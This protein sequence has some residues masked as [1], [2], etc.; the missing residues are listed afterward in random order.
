MRPKAHFAFLRTTHYVLRTLHALYSLS[1]TAIV[2][3]LFGLIVGSFLNVIILRHGVR[4]IGGRSGCMSCGARLP[5]YDMGTVFSWLALRGRCR[6]CR[7][8]ISVQYPLVEA[9]TGALFAL[10]GASLLPFPQ[11]VFGCIILALL[12]AI[13]TYD[14]KHT[15]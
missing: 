15:I 2:F 11:K 1:M 8:R 3:G 14:F 13:A 4:S 5:W 7:A 12:V 10:L 6:A 9:A